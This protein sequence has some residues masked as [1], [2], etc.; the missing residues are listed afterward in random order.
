MVA[1]DIAG[2]ALWLWWNE[3][4][5]QGELAEDWLQARGR[6]GYSAASVRPMKPPDCLCQ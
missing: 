3:Y 1:Q 2:G 4:F 5:F 6:R